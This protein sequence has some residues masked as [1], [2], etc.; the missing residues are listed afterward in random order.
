MPA[1]GTGQLTKAVTTTAGNTVISTSAGRFS[2]VLF[3]TAGAA[4]AITVYDNATTNSGT[5]IGYFAA[6]TSIGTFQA[7]DIPIANGIVI[8]DAAGSTGL[9]IVYSVS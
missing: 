6:S 9:T 1:E 4:N 7:Y 5:V 8:R 2:A 3:T